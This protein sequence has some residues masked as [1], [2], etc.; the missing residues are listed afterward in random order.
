MNSNW[1]EGKMVISFTCLAPLEA[2]MDIVVWRAKMFGPVALCPLTSLMAHM[3]LQTF[4]MVQRE[5]FS[6]FAN[7]NM[8]YKSLHNFHL[9]Y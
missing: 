2:N 1:L 3:E 8:P 4:I 9:D 7:A 6:L 5:K